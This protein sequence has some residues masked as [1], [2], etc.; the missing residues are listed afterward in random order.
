MI[1]E[2]PGLFTQSSMFASYLFIYLLKNYNNLFESC[3]IF[4]FVSEEAYWFDV[5]VD[6]PDS[7][8]SCGYEPIAID[9]FCR[10]SQ[11]LGTEKL[12]LTTN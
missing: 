9:F 5:K 8:T 4:Q 2:W 7:T 3:I 12:D 11:Y 6:M 10:A 1:N